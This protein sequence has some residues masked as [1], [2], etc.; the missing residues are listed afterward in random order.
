MDKAKAENI[1]SEIAQNESP[2][3]VQSIITEEVVRAYPESN[4][5]A[6]LTQFYSKVGELL[7]TGETI[8]SKD[9]GREWKLMRAIVHSGRE[10]LR[11][12]STHFHVENM[13]RGVFT[14]EEVNK[15]L[16]NE[17][18]QLVTPLGIIVFSEDGRMELKPGNF[19]ESVASNDGVIFSILPVEEDLAPNVQ[20]VSMRS[21]VGGQPPVRSV[22][23][24]R[25][26]IRSS[27]A[28]VLSSFALMLGSIT[29]LNQAVNAIPVHQSRGEAIKNVITVSPL[30][31]KPSDTVK[32]VRRYEGGIRKD[33]KEEIDLGGINFMSP[34]PLTIKE[35]RNLVQLQADLECPRN[36]VPLPAGVIE[37]PNMPQGTSA[38]VFLN[39]IIDE[40]GVII[41]HEP[42]SGRLIVHIDDGSSLDVFN[43]CKSRVLNDEDLTG[44][45][46]R[47]FELG[48]K[49][50]LIAMQY[51]SGPTKIVLK[52]ENRILKLKE[53]G[54][55]GED[56]GV[57][58]EELVEGI[59]T[60]G[61]L[62]DE[63]RNQI[64]STPTPILTP[65]PTKTPKVF[66]T[67]VDELD[68]PSLSAEERAE[69]IRIR[70]EKKD[71]ANSFWL[72]TAITIFA[73][74]GVGTAVYNS[75]HQV[76]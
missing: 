53:G 62:T 9:Q 19:R 40:E 28:A 14:P 70:Q 15:Y 44:R 5:I 25:R 18:N 69:I 64:L 23:K 61:S 37:V 32:I 54:F 24:Q 42:N 51:A 8:F 26:D 43:V 55:F 45:C 11:N 20:P 65:K 30:E 47:Q 3:D 56:K 48:T 16:D 59:R 73:L 60:V 76:G 72:G 41:G 17:I 7:E 6:D 57:D 35:K 31:Q 67:E 46:V 66:A 22:G 36:V 12:E 13:L 29:S 10:A 34:E 21:H 75:R 39:P 4:D 33:S 1:N 52:F 58:I 50:K 71:K 2:L 68:D 49:D 74:L 27:P 63:Q 38:C